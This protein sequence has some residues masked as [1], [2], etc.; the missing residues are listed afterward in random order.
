MPI[1]LISARAKRAK[2]Y[3]GRVSCPIIRG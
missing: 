3:E 2:L 1:I